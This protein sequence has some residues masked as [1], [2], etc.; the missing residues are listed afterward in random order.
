MTTAAI[1]DP[2]PY[3]AQALA[4]VRDLMAAVPADR[5]DDPT[6]CSAYDVRALLGHLVATVGR[7]RVIGEGGDPGTEPVVVTG[8]PDDGWADAYAAAAER[9]WP[10]WRAA[11]ML[12][13]EVVAPWGTAPGRTAVWAY[14]NETLVH[15]WDLAV[16]TGQPA[17]F[18]DPAVAEQVLAAVADLIPAGTRGGPVPFAAVVA[19]RP[20]AGPTERLANW[21]GRGRG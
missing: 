3:Y 18:A 1:T 14:L 11:G 20:D 21:S 13:R 6:P 19:S 9:M 10:V 4:W 12:D 7:A 16:A 8:V 17:E 5:L 2:R 15:G